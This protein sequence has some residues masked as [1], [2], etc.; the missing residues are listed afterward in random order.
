MNQA[1]P[2]EIMSVWNSGNK[3]LAIK[4]L[5]D[6]TGLGL[7][8]TKHLLESADAAGLPIE[9]PLQMHRAE[10]SITEPS[11][12]E[13]RIHA[14]IAAG[15]KLEAVKL[16]KEA[17]GLGLAQAKERIDDAMQGQPLDL[18]PAQ[19]SSTQASASPYEVATA[20]GEVPRSRSGLFVT[21]L[22]LVLLLCAVIWNY[23]KSA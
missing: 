10:P 2:A 14:A 7:A 13:L 3:V 19:P 11:P 20:P 15:S 12:T 18:K 8:E 9:M 16:L 4:L 21:M 22:L 5:R 17:T 23:F 6:Q 1:I